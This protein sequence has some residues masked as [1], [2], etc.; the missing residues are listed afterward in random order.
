MRLRRKEKRSAKEKISTGYAN[1]IIG[2]QA[3]LQG[4][5]EFYDLRLVITDLPPP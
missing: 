3:L 2:T 4:D 5:V 1:V